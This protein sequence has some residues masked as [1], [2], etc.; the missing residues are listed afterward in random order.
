MIYSERVKIEVIYQ[1]I[2]ELPVAFARMYLGKLKQYVFPL[3]YVTLKIQTLKIR[4]IC[5]IFKELSVYTTTFII[6]PIIYV[7]IICFFK[8]IYNLIAYTFI[9]CFINLWFLRLFN[10]FYAGCFL[11][12]IIF[13]ISNLEASY[14]LAQ[15]MQD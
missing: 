15:R 11:L 3:Y 10:G 8:L 4:P 1:K 2:I 5:R 6:D 9:E 14:A 12:N 13:M 7:K